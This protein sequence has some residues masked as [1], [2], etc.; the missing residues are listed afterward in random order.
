MGKRK[1]FTEAERKLAAS[2]AIKKWSKANPEKLLIYQRAFNVRNPELYLWRSA[3]G[4]ARKSNLEFTISTEDISIPSHCPLLGVE[5]T[6]IFGMGRVDTNI[7]I[8]RIDNS[9][10]YIK[11]NIQ[12]VSDLANRMKQ[13]ATREQLIAFAKRIL[14][15]YE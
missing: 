1:Y 4:R 8:D 14:Q 2:E 11:E 5:L 15:M 13:N 10:G 3:K 7:S 9:K 6:H 12:I